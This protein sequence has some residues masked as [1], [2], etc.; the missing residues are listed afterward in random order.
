MELEQVVNR[1]WEDYEL[2]PNNVEGHKK[3]EDITGASKKVT[4]LREEIKGLR[5][6]KCRL[7]RRI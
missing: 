5:K 3:P 4:G 2:T 7:N 6:Y 1:M